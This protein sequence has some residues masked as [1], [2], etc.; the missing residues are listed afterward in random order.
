MADPY[1]RKGNRLSTLIGLNKNKHLKAENQ[2]L[3]NQMSVKSATH[4]E[5]EHQLQQQIALEREKSAIE[6]E[7][8]KQ[9]YEAKLLNDQRK[10]EERRQ[11]D[12]E[13]NRRQIEAVNFHMETQKKAI[14]E[15]I[16]RLR[17]EEQ[18][19]KQRE[20]QKQ[21]EE[22]EQERRRQKA[23]DDAK[24]AKRQRKLREEN[25]RLREEQERQ[26]WLRRNAPENLRE[27]RELIR[28]KYALDVHIWNNRRVRK[29]VRPEIEKKMEKAD[30][31]LKQIHEIVRSWEPSD[32]WDTGEWELAV[33]IREK[34]LEGGKRKWSEN[35]PW[36][37]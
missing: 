13:E 32:Q 12:I 1:G 37:S 19:R 30:A 2:S 17:D 34:L 15:Q 3:I 20:R 33:E 7:R 25:A 9:Q 28:E 6:N 29:P 8:H 35:P 23:E 26:D 22:Q 4:R 36:T 16:Q 14:E 27:L 5:R 10:L 11:Q 21:K 24:E 18:R 31:I